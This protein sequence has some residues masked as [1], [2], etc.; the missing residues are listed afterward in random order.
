MITDLYA[1]T[2]DR[3]QRPDHRYTL[4]QRSAISAS[5]SRKV[6]TKEHAEF[7][8]CMEMIDL[9]RLASTRVISD[10]DAKTEHADL[11]HGK[12]LLSLS[13]ARWRISARWAPTATRTI[14]VSRH[15]RPRRLNNGLYRTFA[16]PVVRR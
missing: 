7:A 6:A 12:Y 4:H 16:Q 10:V 14:G 15:A 1:H 13:R 5:L 2:D 11:L 9:M 8:S 3:R